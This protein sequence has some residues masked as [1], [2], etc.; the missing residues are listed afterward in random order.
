M[1]TI[2]VAEAKAMASDP[3]YIDTGDV[4]RM[5]I[6]HEADGQESLVDLAAPGETEEQAIAA[7]MRRIGDADGDA[8]DL[9]CVMIA[10]IA[11]MKTYKEELTKATIEDVVLGEDGAEP[12]SC[13]LPDNDDRSE[14]CQAGVIDG[15]PVSVYYMLTPADYEVM[16]EDGDGSKIGWNDRVDRIELNLCACDR[17]GISEEA[18]DAVVARLG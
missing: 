13:R 16:G 12:T 6:L 3:E 1:R 17:Q 18:I 2:T 15:V 7:Y 14:W 10:G 11:R 9:C 8:S 5:A 4:G